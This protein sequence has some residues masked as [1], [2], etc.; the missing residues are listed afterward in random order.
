VRGVGQLH[1]LRPFATFGTVNVTLVSDHAVTVAVVVRRFAAST[2]RNALPATTTATVNG[3]V[4]HQRDVHRAEVANGL[5]NVQLANSAHTNAN[6]I[7]FTALTAK[8]IPVTFTVNNASP[9]S[10][11]DYIFL[12][13]AGIELG[14][15]GTTFDT[16]HRA[17]AGPQLSELVPQRIDAC[18]RN[19]SIQVHQNCV[20]AGR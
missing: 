12:S 3:V 1:V 9:T 2:H 19:D 8:L 6:T 13:G 18:G 15:W 20:R 5:Y 4:R 7:Q 17:D 14:N 10:V 11:G 16:S